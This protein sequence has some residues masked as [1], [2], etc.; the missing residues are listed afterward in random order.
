[1]AHRFH[2]TVPALLT[3]SQKGWAPCSA[4]ECKVSIKGFDNLGQ[5]S[6]KWPA[7]QALDLNKF[8]F[9]PQ[10]T[11]AMPLGAVLDILGDAKAKNTAKN[12]L[13]SSG[14]LD[15][16]RIK[17]LTKKDF[18][19]F[20]KISRSDID[21]EFLGFFSLLTSYCVLARFTDPKKGPKH[22]LPVMPRT[23]FVAQYTKFIEPKL[24]KQFLDKTVS[25]LDVVVKVSGNAQLA[26]EGFKWNT[27][28]TVN[29]PEV[30]ADKAK[31]LESGKLDIEDFINHIQG[32]DKKT[33][34]ALP[35]MDLLKL[36]DKAMR[37]GQ[38]GSLSNKMETVLGSTKEAP[39]F[40]FRELDPVLGP[41]LGAALESY[42]KKVIAYHGKFK[43]REAFIEGDTDASQE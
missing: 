39:I 9:G 11:T 38:I 17:I 5:W 21:D 6:V 26:K 30:W 33:K 7:A 22:L 41:K 18:E 3:R 16:A 15:A 20:T 29:I 32:F 24:K 40:E 36:M 2:G 12:P 23:D 1:M 13:A 10:V 35:K 27:G 28:R 31:N 34:K 43:K 19:S 37:H 14:A 25:L 4:K 42:E 8:P